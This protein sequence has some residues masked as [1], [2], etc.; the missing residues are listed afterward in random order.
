MVNKYRTCEDDAITTMN[1]D[2]ICMALDDRDEAQRVY[3]TF[4]RDSMRGFKTRRDAVIAS[5]QYAEWRDYQDQTIGNLTVPG[6]T[7]D[8]RTVY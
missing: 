1:V 2:R 3:E 5:I 7:L 6:G 8:Y 4:T